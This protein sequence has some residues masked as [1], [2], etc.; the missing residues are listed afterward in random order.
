M[1]EKI[2]QLRGALQRTTD[3]MAS[4]QTQ[5]S[6][7]HEWQELIDANRSALADGSLL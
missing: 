6:F 4:W 2:E 3:Y 7:N 1:E 5:Q